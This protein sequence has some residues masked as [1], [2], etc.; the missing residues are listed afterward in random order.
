LGANA[1]LNVALRGWPWIRAVFLLLM[2]NT[3]S[4]PQTVTFT[5]NGKNAQTDDDD[6]DGILDWWEYY[7]FGHTSYGAATDP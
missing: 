5:M 4:Q 3:S 1:A 2:T 7:Y 6:N